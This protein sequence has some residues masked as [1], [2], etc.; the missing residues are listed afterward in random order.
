MP[1]VGVDDMRFNVQAKEGVKHR[2]LQDKAKA[3]H[4]YHPL[5]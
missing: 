1:L 2:H 3:Y 5:S 4:P